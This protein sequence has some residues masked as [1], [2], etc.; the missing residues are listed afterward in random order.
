[1]FFEFLLMSTEIFHLFKYDT[2]WDP[3]QLELVPVGPPSPSRTVTFEI[4]PGTG[5]DWDL[6]PHPDCDTA[7]I[8][9]TGGIGLPV[10]DCE[11]AHN[12]LADRCNA[13]EI[14]GELE[15]KGYQRH[16]LGSH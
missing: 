4:W 6:K 1:V 3:N 10:E 2:F 7:E 5:K 11:N 14:Y 16:L 8:T 9:W 12:I 15:T 13:R